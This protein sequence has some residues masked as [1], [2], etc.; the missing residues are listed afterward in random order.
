LLIISSLYSSRGLKQRLPQNWQA[1]RR[2]TSP[3]ARRRGFCALRA[4]ERSVIRRLISACVCVANSPSPQP[5]HPRQANE[6]KG[7]SG[8]LPEDSRPLWQKDHCRSKGGCRSTGDPPYAHVIVRECG[9]SSTLLPTLSESNG[10]V[11]TGFPAF[12]FSLLPAYGEKELPP[13]L[14][15]G[16]ICGKV[17]ADLRPRPQHCMRGAFLVGR[18]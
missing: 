15:G 2:R 14:R 3:C 6:G 9:R 5:P 16:A 13:A 4:D 11:L 8:D 1:R 18:L 17:R 10:M 7:F 12:A